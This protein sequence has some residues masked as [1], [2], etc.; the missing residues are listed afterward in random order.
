MSH[1]LARKGE[2]KR[3]GKTGRHEKESDGRK[4]PQ[5]NFLFTAL[6]VYRH[7]AVIK[8]VVTVGSYYRLV[9]AIIN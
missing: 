4:Q 2:Q 6:P 7:C 8:L 9:F 1:F 3:A 5:N